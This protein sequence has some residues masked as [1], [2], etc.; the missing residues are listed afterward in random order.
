MVKWWWRVVIFWNDPWRCHQPW[1]GNPVWASFHLFHCWPQVDPVVARL[2]HGSWLIWLPKK[3]WNPQTIEPSKIHSKKRRNSLLVG[4]GQGLCRPRWVGRRG[5][6]VGRG[7]MVVSDGAKCRV[8]RRKVLCRTARSTV[9]D[10]AKCRVGRRRQQ[11]T[12]KVTTTK[13]CVKS[14]PNANLAN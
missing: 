3:G 4:F 12:S 13:A 1:L 11:K 2:A 10:G 9:S 14:K 5:G 6:R 8:G 7:G